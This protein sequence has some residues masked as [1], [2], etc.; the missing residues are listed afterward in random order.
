MI[1]FN[2]EDFFENEFENF[3]N[4]FLEKLF[5]GNI[6]KC[7]I[8]KE[9]RFYN[10]ALLYNLDMIMRFVKSNFYFDEFGENI[11]LD[12]LKRSLINEIN[13]KASVYEML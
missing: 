12:D 3:K 7:S 13:D 6:G 4:N 8:E 11:N 5:D 9:V 10:E 1:E 2:Y